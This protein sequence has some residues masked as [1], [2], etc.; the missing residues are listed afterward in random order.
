[1]QGNCCWNA[2]TTSRQQS[3]QGRL[4]FQLRGAQ[5][6]RLVYALRKL[7]RQTSPH[8]RYQEYLSKAG[9]QP[10]LLP[11][12]KYEEAMQHTPPKLDDT[13]ATDKTIG[14]FISYSHADEDYKIRLEKHLK[15]ISRSLPLNAWSDRSLFAGGPVDEQNLP[16]NSTPPILSCC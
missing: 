5:L 6:D 7:V 14:L 12:F 11:E 2:N 4:H 15:A 8:R 9:E 3:T 10:S 13:Q 16:S 1:M